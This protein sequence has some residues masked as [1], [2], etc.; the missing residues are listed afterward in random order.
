MLRDAIL[1]T[2][3]GQRLGFYHAQRFLDAGF[4]LVVTYRTPR[5]SIEILAQAGALTIQADFSTP[6]G[7]E[8]FI[9]TLH[10]QVQSLRCIIHNASVW[11]TDADLEADPACF[12]TLFNLHVRAPY[13]INLAC[14]GLLQACSAPF[15]DIIHITDTALQKGSATRSAYLASKAALDSLTLSH[16]ARLAPK[17]KVN[18]IAPG[19]ILFNEGDSTTYRQDRLSRSALGFEPGPDVIWQSIRYL[20]DNSF[21][22]GST[23]TVDGGR[24]IK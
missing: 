5:P 3:A 23:L 14:A 4:A 12:D 1:L 15:A 16:A 19:L 22:T 7:I 18:S 2:G 24:K 11:L 9:E 21:I 10:S 17:I 13:R 8:R 20:M 6:E